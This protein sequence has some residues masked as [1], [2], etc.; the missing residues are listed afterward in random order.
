MVSYYIYMIQNLIGLDSTIFT[1][2]NSFATK[3][4]NL[5]EYVAKIWISIE[6]Q[7]KI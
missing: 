7:F 4:K 5:D 6:I 3:I 2:S 1:F